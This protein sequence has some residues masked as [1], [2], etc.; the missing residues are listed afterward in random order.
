LP[1]NVKILH[2]AGTAVLWDLWHRVL[3]S[4]HWWKPQ[5]KWNELWTYD[6]PFFHRNQTHVW[7]PSLQGQRVHI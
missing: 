5:H 7:D 1:P 4:L 3:Y 6:H 2:V